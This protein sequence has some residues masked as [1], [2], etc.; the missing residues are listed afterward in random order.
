MMLLLMSVA[1]TTSGLQ[2]FLCGPH[3]L[4][5][6]TTDM[7]DWQRRKHLSRLVREINFHKQILVIMFS[8]ADIFHNIFQLISLL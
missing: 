8:E 5:T 1:H 3:T 4:P 6:I 7:Y 2:L